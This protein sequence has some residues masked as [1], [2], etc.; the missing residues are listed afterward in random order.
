VGLVVRVERIIEPGRHRLA[1][2][3]EAARQGHDQCEQQ[4][5][6]AEP[7][8]GARADEIDRFAGAA[9]REPAAEH[10]QELPAERVEVPCAG[11]I[12]RQVPAEMACGEIEQERGCQRQIEL[13]QHCPQHQRIDQHQRDIERQHV[14]VDRLERQDQALIER[15]GRILHEARDVEFVLQIGVVVAL[16]EV[17]DLGDV[18]HEQQDVRDIDLPGPLDQSG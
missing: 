4:I 6:A 11:R 2:F 3:G 14:H 18:D 8:E 1:E 17:A 16:R 5:G 7:Q 9:E 10:E 15:L 12:G 13:P